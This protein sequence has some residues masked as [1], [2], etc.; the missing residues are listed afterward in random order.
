MSAKQQSEQPDR[1]PPFSVEAEQAAIGCC[2]LDPQNAIPRC[3]EMMPAGSETAYDLRHATVLDILFEMYD[4]REPIEL[5]SVVQ[6]L[7]DRGFLEQVGGVAYLA[8]CQDATPSAA[9]VDYYLDIVREKYL[10]RRLLRTCTEICGQVYECGDKVNELVDDAERRVMSVSQ[11]RISKGEVSTKTIVKAALTE[12]EAVWSRQGALGGLETGFID[13]DRLTDGLHGGEMIVIAARPSVGKTAWMMNVMEHLA[14]DLNLPVG[15]FSLEMTSPQLIKRSLSS[16]ARVNLREMRDRGLMEE[17]V[18]KL[19]AASDRLG[20]APLHIDDEGGLSI[21]QIRAK[22]RRWH[23]KYGIKAV[24]IDY[25][26]LANALGGKRKFENRQ[27]EIT[28]ISAGTKNLAKELNIPVI[29]LSQLNREVEKDKDR[30]PRLSDLRESGSI[31]Q[32][33][34]VV[35]MLFEDKKDEGPKDI[36]IPINMLLAKNRNGDRGDIVRFTF[37]KTFTRFESASRIQH[38]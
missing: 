15:V 28:E 1:L 9:N 2:L 38:D 17:D 22:A 7:K 34:D 20:K 36:A 8:T 11:S 13:F 19:V 21:M 6:K 14:V 4:A 16:I 35:G 31:E 30:M 27:Q 25:L 32:D 29:V 24:G 23:Q 37:L 12:L 10:L 26:Q 5:P 3:I 33:A 18:P